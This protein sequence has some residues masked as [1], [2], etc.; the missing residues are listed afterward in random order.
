MPSRF[1]D[2]LDAHLRAYIQ[3][4]YGGVNRNNTVFS[5]TV[6]AQFQDLLDKAEFTH[7]QNVFYRTPTIIIPDSMF[8]FPPISFEIATDEPPEEA[9]TESSME[10]D[11]FLKEFAL[12]EAY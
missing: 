12:K 2:A 10:L 7:F 1:N 9:T 4:A 5:D 6:L 8:E 3:T 11:E